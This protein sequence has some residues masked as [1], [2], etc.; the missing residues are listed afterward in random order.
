MD[1]KPCVLI[2]DDISANI[3]ILANCLKDYYQIKV[4]TSAENQGNGAQR[5][6][7]F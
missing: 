1:E 7:D 2:V 3:Q 5:S 6:D 4:A